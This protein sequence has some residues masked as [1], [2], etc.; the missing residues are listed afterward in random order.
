MTESLGNEA[1]QRAQELLRRGAELSQGKAVTDED[2]Q[3]AAAH[4]AHAH[5]RDQRARDRELQRHYDAGVAHEHAAK[6][7]ELAADEGIGDVAAHR[8]AALAEREAARRN[9]ISAQESDKQDA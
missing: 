1:A 4:A 2:V 5:E 7:H 3:R 6:V 8:A 9:L